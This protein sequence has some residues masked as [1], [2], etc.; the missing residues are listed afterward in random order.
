[1]QDQDNQ[2]LLESAPRA[3]GALKP[4]DLVRLNSG[5]SLLTVD[6][7]RGDEVTVAWLDFDGRPQSMTA[8]AVCFTPE[9][10]RAQN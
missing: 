8:P 9:V 1:M 5:S 2:K 10:R 4:G 3:Q 7:V 6:M